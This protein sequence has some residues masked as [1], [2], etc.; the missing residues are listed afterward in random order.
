VQT[1]PASRSLQTVAACCSVVCAVQFAD[2]PSCTSQ[3]TIL[4]YILL[5]TG[6]MLA[7]P[8]SLLQGATGTPCPA[9]RPAK[10]VQRATLAAA[11]PAAGCQLASSNRS[12]SA[13]DPL[14]P[15]NARSTSF[16]VAL[17]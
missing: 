12:V 13:I 1:L 17:Q 3:F 14:P 5:G 9:A 7:A 15:A 8:P 10:S 6:C 16:R 4:L 2:L 11:V